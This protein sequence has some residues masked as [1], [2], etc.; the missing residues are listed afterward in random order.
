MNE[1]FHLNFVPRLP[2]VPI[3]DVVVETYA[4]SAAELGQ[5][6]H[7]VVLLTGGEEHLAMMITVIRPTAGAEITPDTLASFGLIS[8][9]HVIIEMCKAPCLLYEPFLSE[10]LALAI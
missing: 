8:G 4:V 1:I 10:I 7:D 9:W 2:E 5:D 3:F 6:L